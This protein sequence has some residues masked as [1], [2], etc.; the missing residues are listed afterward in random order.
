M[1]SYA[2]PL[3]GPIQRDLDWAVASRPYPGQS[4]SGD[5]H[6]FKPF[7]D[8]VL[9][10]VVDALGHGP[11]A[12]AAA[13]LAVATME[14]HAEEYPLDIVRRCH[15]VLRGTRGVVMSLASIYWMDNTLTWLAIGD[16]EAR[17]FPPPT[18]GPY[19][20]RALVTRGGIVGA[21]LLPEARPWVVPI[22]GG[23]TLVFATDGVRSGFA[24]G[25]RLDA[26]PQQI[27]D[28][29]LTAYQRGTDDALVLVARTPPAT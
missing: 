16:V 14:E 18:A 20:P 22:A 9:L 7:A 10:G 15:R 19:P 11:E 23:D 4:V 2:L 24:D 25:V 1:G 6:A 3:G 27:A 8:G 5:L 17:L 26:S 12:E 21:G 28:E 13:R 29:I